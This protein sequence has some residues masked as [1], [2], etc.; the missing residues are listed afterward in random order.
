MMVRSYKGVAFLKVQQ[1][2]YLTCKYQ[3]VSTH[4]HLIRHHRR[5]HLM[6]KPYYLDQRT[7]FYICQRSL[8]NT[9]PD[10]L[11]V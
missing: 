3:T 9:L 5:N 1:L 10:I 2:V 7:S 11:I 8:L 6:V 4:K